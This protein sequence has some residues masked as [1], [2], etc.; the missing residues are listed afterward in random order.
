MREV[1]VMDFDVV[2]M[3]INVELRYCFFELLVCFVG[4]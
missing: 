2:I 3:I 4:C 1:G